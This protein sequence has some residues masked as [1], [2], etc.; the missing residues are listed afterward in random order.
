MSAVYLLTYLLG[1]AGAGCGGAGRF[2][3][4]VSPIQAVWETAGGGLLDQS[5]A[6]GGLRR[7]LRVHAGL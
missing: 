4:L 2:V 6:Y 3:Q 1:S 7:R 5:V